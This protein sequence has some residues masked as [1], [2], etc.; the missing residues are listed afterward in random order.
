MDDATLRQREA[1]QSPSSSFGDNSAWRQQPPP[2]S[3]Y[4][5]SPS[6]GNSGNFLDEVTDDASPTAG[7]DPYPPIV[8]NASSGGSAWDHV[9]HGSPSSDQ[10]NPRGLPLPGM[11]QKPGSSARE[12]QQREQEHQRQTQRESFSYESGEADRQLA[13]EMEQRKF[14]EMLDRER[15]KSRDR[16][17]EGTRR[18]FGGPR[19]GNEGGGESEGESAWD[20]RRRRD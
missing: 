4:P 18:G 10:S 11:R 8:R 7:S 13:R 6:A 9:R 17:V 12:L 16:E 1:E 14:D 3:P 15:H 19:E 5:R 2:Q 20:R